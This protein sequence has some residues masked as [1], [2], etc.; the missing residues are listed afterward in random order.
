MRNTTRRRVGSVRAVGA[1]R[2]YLKQRHR[3]VE[4]RRFSP[5]HMRWQTCVHVQRRVVQNHIP[6]QTVWV[7]V[8]HV[9]SSTNDFGRVGGDRCGSV[10]E[11]QSHGQVL[12]IDPAGTDQLRFVEQRNGVV[13]GRKGVRAAALQGQSEYI[14]GDGG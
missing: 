4:Q 14:W 8:V 11:G 5:H 7:G 1:V 9:Q 13:E 6:S 10:A 3:I 2:A 12:L